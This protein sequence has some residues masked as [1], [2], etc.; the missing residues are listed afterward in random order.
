MDTCLKWTFCFV[1]GE[2]YIFSKFNPPNTDADTIYGSLS[3]RINRIWL[4][5]IDCVNKSTDLG[6]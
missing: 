5:I 1:P 3:V 4:Y 6:G 2:S